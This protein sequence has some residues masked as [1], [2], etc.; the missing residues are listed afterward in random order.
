MLFSAS[1]VVE[2]LFYAINLIF[3]YI[4][5]WLINLRQKSF[6]YVMQFRINC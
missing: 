2:I 6:I 1:A 3:G 4:L 5:Q